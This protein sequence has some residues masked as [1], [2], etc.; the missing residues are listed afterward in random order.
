MN[1]DELRQQLNNMPTLREAIA[2]G[3]N[4]IVI[5]SDT[6]QTYHLTGITICMND[7]VVLFHAVLVKEDKHEHN[8]RPD[9]GPAN[10]RQDPTD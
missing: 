9:A 2:R 6:C 8:T 3:N 7:P 5:V 4:E 1:L 10:G